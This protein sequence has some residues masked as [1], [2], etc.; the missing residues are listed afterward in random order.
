M[1][2]LKLLHLAGM[3]A[4]AGS[5]LALLVVAQASPYAGAD[6]QAALRQAA[7]DMVSMAIVP[8]LLALLCSGGLLM[9]ARPAHLGAR[10]VWAKAALGTAAAA[11]TLGVLHP[12]NGRA[13]ALAL[14][15]AQGS[16]VLAP[17]DAAL[18]TERIAATVVLALLVLAIAVA[19]WRPRLGRRE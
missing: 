1:R 8:A 10:W 17:L 9:V 5:L 7:A 6:A 4:L 11:L 15:G 14:L 2:L 18:A 12:A 16:P 13:A 3:A 19:L